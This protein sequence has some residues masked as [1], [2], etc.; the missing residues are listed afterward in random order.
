M[1]GLA[2]AGLVRGDVEALSSE[3]RHAG[4][5]ARLSS[6]TVHVLP[7][8]NKSL[9]ETGTS[10]GLSSF[11]G[12]VACVAGLGPKTVST[13][14]STGKS[15]KELHPPYPSPGSGLSKGAT[16]AENATDVL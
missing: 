3:P 11:A 15:P 10:K 16:T 7:G 6:Q 4:K 8:F 5:G 14:A 1:A 9:R 12:R 13:P 2:M